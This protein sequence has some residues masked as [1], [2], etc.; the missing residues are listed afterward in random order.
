MFK[1]KDQGNIF[2][3]DKVMG[4]FVNSK[5]PPTLLSKM[6]AKDSGHFESLK[7]TVTLFRR[8]CPGLFKKSYLL[9]KIFAMGMIIPYC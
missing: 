4:D 1:K 8:Y 6:A 7:L 5:W 9:K 2:F 3:L